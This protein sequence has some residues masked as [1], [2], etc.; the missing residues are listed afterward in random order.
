MQKLAPE[1]FVLESHELTL[2]GVCSHCR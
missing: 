1:G 2:Y